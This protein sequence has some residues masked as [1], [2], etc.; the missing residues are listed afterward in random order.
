LRSEAQ[1]RF[2]MKKKFDAVKFQQEVRKELSEKYNTN[3]DEFMR[4]LNLR[5]GDSKTKAAYKKNRVVAQTQDANRG[6]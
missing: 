3:R 2:Y 1:E 4:E 6:Q 5:Y